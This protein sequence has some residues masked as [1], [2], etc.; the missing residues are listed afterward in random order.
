MPLLTTT[1][2][3]YSVAMFDLNGTIVRVL[4]IE[5][6]RWQEQLKVNTLNAREASNKLR[7]QIIQSPERIKTDMARMHNAIAAGKKATEDKGQ[8]LTELRGQKENMLERC[9][10]GE[11]GVKLL[12]AISGELDKQK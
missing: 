10:A 2:N 3:P 11:Q 8:R 5:F 12:T 9:E 6:C 1:N 4:G 7:P